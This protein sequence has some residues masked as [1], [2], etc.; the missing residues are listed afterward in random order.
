MSC[1]VDIPT[2]VIDTIDVKEFR[3]CDGHSLNLVVIYY[4]FLRKEVQSVT[5]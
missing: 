3:L 1:L 2:V 5:H 4:S